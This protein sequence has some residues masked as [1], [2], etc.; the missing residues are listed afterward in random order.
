MNDLFTEHE[1]F[2]N[3][4]FSGA[5]Y[6]A[7]HDKQRLTGQ[8]EKIYDLMKDGRYRTLAEMRMRLGYPEASISAQLR[9]LKKP[10][11]GSH[12]LNKRS[13]GN[14]DIGLWE[15]QLLINK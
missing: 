10:A 1:T 14:R 9:N 6:E 2:A 11:F 15:Y 8:L 13:R 5:C 12:T 7:R 4:R 3:A